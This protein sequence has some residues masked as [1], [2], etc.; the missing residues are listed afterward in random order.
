MKIKELLRNSFECLKFTFLKV[1]QQRACEARLVQNEEGDSFTTLAT[2]V[3]FGPA[4]FVPAGLSG[5]CVELQTQK[6]GNSWI[7]GNLAVERWFTPLSL[8][9]IEGELVW[10][11]ERQISIRFDNQNKL[12]S[13]SVTC[14]L[15]LRCYPSFGNKHWLTMHVIFSYEQHAWVVCV[16]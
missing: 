13:S 14:L 12:I 16:C 1:Q 4:F 7:R 9:I 10:P 5:A 8:F 15:K 2:R 11:T 6:F 3:W